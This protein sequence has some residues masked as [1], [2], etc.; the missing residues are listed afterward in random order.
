MPMGL[1]EK[2]RT[3]D[4]ALFELHRE[5]ESA[6]KRT[7]GRDNWRGVYAM[8]VKLNQESRRMCENNFAEVRPDAR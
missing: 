7:E 4:A 5:M 3:A 8:R 6:M 2:F 1:R